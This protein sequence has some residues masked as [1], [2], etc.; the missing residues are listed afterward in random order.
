MPASAWAST[1]AHIGLGVTL[2]GITG[3]TVWRSEA[4]DVLGPG[5]SMNVGGYTLTLDHVETVQGPNYS[6]ERA[7]IDVSDHGT[8]I[9]TVGPEKR[10]YPTQGMAV[11]DTAIRTTGFEDLY[12]AL[13]DQREN[14]RWTVRAYTNPLA[15]F[16]W[17]GGAF[18]ALGGLASLWGRLRRKA[19]VPDAQAAA[20]E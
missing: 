18:M 16:I 17:F 10:M 4:I 5:Q 19:R 13:G 2:L 11:S 7:I 8:L 9:T 6:A 15:P 12:L 1:L 3:T 14:G 20:A